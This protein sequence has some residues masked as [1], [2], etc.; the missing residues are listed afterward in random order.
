MLS[1][2]F[3]LMVDPL[4]QRRRNEKDT[5]VA[6]GSVQQRD[7]F[8]EEGTVAFSIEEGLTYRNLTNK[9]SAKSS[10][11]KRKKKTPPFFMAGEVLRL[12]LWALCFL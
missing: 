7:R 10:L 1:K 11:R 8:R 6:M 3:C 2:L 9:P 4:C 12:S 5:A